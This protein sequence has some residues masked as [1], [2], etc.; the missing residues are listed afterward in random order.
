MEAQR[1][2]LEAAIR[3]LEE[4]LA[5]ARQDLLD[6]DGGKLSVGGQKKWAAGKHQRPGKGALPTLT[7]SKGVFSWYRPKGQKSIQTPRYPLPTTTAQVQ[8]PRAA[9]HRVTT[10][11][12]REHG[13]G[14]LANPDLVD[15]L[16]PPD[17]A[18]TW[19]TIGPGRM[20]AKQCGPGGPCGL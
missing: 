6:F 12:T 4:S 8:G 19:R 2:D 9:Q 14:Q 18:E 11:T 3:R 5:E 7:K 10:P 20:A 13:T 1:A 15:Q 16:P 17:R